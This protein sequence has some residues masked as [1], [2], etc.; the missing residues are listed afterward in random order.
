MLRRWHIAVSFTTHLSKLMLFLLLS[1]T[2]DQC[3]SGGSDPNGTSVSTNLA[4]SSG[5]ALPPLPLGMGMGRK[6]KDT[7]LPLPEDGDG[8]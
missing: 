7:S 5:T 4:T 1:E 8:W 2:G 6:G 3:T